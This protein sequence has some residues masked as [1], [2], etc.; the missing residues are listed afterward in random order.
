MYISLF[1]GRFYFYEI[2]CGDTQIHMFLRL[3]PLVF[4]K[5]S[6]RQILMACLYILY[7]LSVVTTDTILQSITQIAEKCTYCFFL[8]GGMP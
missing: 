1:S 2:G 6:A 8:G 3:F 7:L 4:S 5:I